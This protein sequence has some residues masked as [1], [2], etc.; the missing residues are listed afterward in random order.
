[1]YQKRRVTK[2]YTNYYNR[3]C[4]QRTHEVRNLQ[5]FSLSFE[6]K[7]RTQLP[8]KFLRTWEKRSTRERE[9]KKSNESKRLLVR[10]SGEENERKR[11]EE[12]KGKESFG[13]IRASSR[14]GEARSV[15]DL[16]RDGGAMENALEPRE[17]N[18][19]KERANK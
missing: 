4:F 3:K 7:S 19:L 14:F 2:I 8:R 11:E 6:L 15:V 17:I 1:M 10:T 9:R 18:V 5:L 12:R 16:V 13:F